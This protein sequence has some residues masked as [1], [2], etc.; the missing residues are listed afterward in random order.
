MTKIAF[1]LWNKR[2]APVF[3]VARNLWIVETDENDIIGQSGKRFATDDTQ[4]RALRLTTLQVDQLVCGAITRSSSEVLAEHGIMVIS[5]I[6]GEL[7]QVI[8]AWL[9]DS[10]KDGHLA[11]PGCSRGKRRSAQRY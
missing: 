4:D 6:A 5:F 11:M 2:I 7:E 3:D 9:S 10:L 8:Q 1:S